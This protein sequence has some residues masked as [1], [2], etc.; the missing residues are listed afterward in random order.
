MAQSIVTGGLLDSPSGII[1]LGLNSGA[2]PTTGGGLVTLGLGL[3]PSRLVLQ[4]LAPNAS[5]V[6]V[7]TDI[8][9]GDTSIVV[10]W[11]GTAT[12]YR[13]DGGTTTALPDG[14]SPDTITGLTENTEYNSPG[15]ELSGD[16]GSTWSDPVAF[17][18]LNPGE[19]GG[20]MDAL[21][22]LSTV[23]AS[24]VTS[25]GFT[26]TVAYDY[27]GGTN[28]NSPV[29][30]WV[31][32]TTAAW[33]S[34][35]TGAQIKDGFL[36][37]GSTAA[38]YSGSESAP[39]SGSGT[40]T[41]ATATTGASAATEYTIAWVVYD[42]VT[43]TYS[44]PVTGTVTTAFDLNASAVALSGALAISG[45]LDITAA[46]ELDLDPAVL[47]LSGAL[48]ISGDIEIGTSHDLAADPIAL[49]GSLA[50]SGDIESSVDP[51]LDIDAAAI[52][53]SG[54]LSVSGDIDIG[55]SFDVDASAV[56][57]AGAI[58]VSGDIQSS[59]DPIVVAR[60]RTSGGVGVEVFID[61]AIED[62]DEVIEIMQVLVAA[63]V[64]WEA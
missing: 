60:G 59:T 45:D 3:S 20:G 58:T 18:T 6:P 17:G 50:V 38:T 36:S 33:I 21:P 30:Y 63:G 43:D 2:A 37:D 9:P 19:G 64:L 26:P 8:E 10:T 31:S 7:I 12:H 46:P 28:G 62:D 40:I 53:L 29:G 42:P 44:T 55:T 48:S 27:S 23:S 11:T 14:T 61:E 34:T 1:R 54:S 57:L 41:E 15:L 4:G 35:P 25:S 49:A 51:M 22:T 13:I 32:S 39:G 16:S 52:A 47:A 56:A 24:S 5:G